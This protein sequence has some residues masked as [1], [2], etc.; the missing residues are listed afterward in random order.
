MIEVD[1]P[2]YRTF[3]FRHLV[4]DVNGT[5]AADG[6]LI[7]GVAELLGRIRTELAIHLVTADTYGRQQALG[8][9]LELDAVVIP[10]EG[11]A[12]AKLD[13]VTRLGADGVVAIGNGANDAA[14]L[15]GAALGIAVIGA[16]GA[17]SAALCR[18]DVVTAGILP[19]LQLLLHRRRLAATLRR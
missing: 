17:A 5:I 3:R 12:A 11:Q 15:E 1:I 4:L 7:D 13:Y 6:G 19:A 2:G 18:A 16:E 9:A 8:R 10:A 14:M